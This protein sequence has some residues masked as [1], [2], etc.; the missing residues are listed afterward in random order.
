[1]N[2][3]IKDIARLSGVGISTV[4][5]V[6]NNTGA[7][8]E[9]TRRKVMAVVEQL[10][11]IPNNSARNLKITASKN[12]A[13]LV[14]GITHPFFNKLIR[15][16][17]QKVA[18]R[19]YTLLLQNIQNN[20]DELNKAIQ[21][22]LDKNLCGVIIIGGS[23]QYSDEKFKQ[24]GIPCVLLTISANEKVDKKL[25]SSVRIDDEAEGFKATEHLISLGHRKIGFLY[26]ATSDI[27]TPNTLRFNGYKRALEQYNIPFNSNLVPTNYAADS[28]GY[29]IGFNMMQQLLLNN[30]DMTAL[31]TFADIIAIGAAKAALTMGYKIPD[32]ISII[33]FDGIEAAEFFHPSIDTVSQPSTEMALSSIDILLD[34]MQGGDTKHILYDCV[35][36]KRGSTKLIQTY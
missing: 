23:F 12:I 22:K 31:F 19:G 9:I 16:I 33:G 15:V 35:L 27:V 3:T 2:P 28:S 29:E 30:R 5:R 18:L 13:L 10:N 24:L 17:E 4:S 26:N 14:K 7:T 20:I 1:M 25:Y 36:L 34:M 32:N 21:E 11:F 8:R 6:I